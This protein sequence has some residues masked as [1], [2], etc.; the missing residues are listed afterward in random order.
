LIRSLW[1]Q[2]HWPSL[3][4]S[5]LYFDV[6]FMVW[7]LLGALGVVISQDIPMTV[8]QQGLMVALPILG[9]SI[10][11]VLLGWYSD[12]FG[13]K[14]AGML[15][16]SASMVPLFCLWIGGTRLPEIYAYGF[17]LGV[18]GASFA[19]ALPLA[20]RWYPKEN[21]G[22]VMGIVGAGNSGTLLATWFAPRL[23]QIFGSWHAVFGVALIPMSII[24]LLY[25]IAAK[26]P[27]MQ[28]TKSSQA[29]D[30][31]RLLKEKDTW[32]F[33]YFYS[34]TFGGFVGFSS[35]L[36]LYFHGQFTLSPLQAANI[37]ALCVLS[38]S[39]VR[40]VGGWLADRI[41]GV[42]LLKGLFFSISIM[43]GI[44]PFL[45]SLTLQAGCFFVMMVCL[46]MGNGSVFQLVPQRF[47]QEI[48]TVTG[49]VGA[50]GGVGGFYLPFLLGLVREQSGSFVPGFIF[51]C[52]VVGIAWGCLLAVKQQWLSQW[53]DIHRSTTQIQHAA[54]K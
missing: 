4:A 19:A 53:A 42:S 30:F 34:I 28:Q 24:L 43:L 32:L 45:P 1:K 22:L 12:R 15:G 40:P 6:S 29:S 27:V 49:L 13:A 48:G 9:G 47:R 54:E 46:G 25:L 17:L 14:R 37:A 2:G 16:M 11:R 31:I 3:L 38:G 51:L 44:L 18:A 23:A 36:P 7:V 8:S 21:Q 52:A 26:E 41:G 5:F 33:C 20:S 50:A 35:F 10:F 39:F